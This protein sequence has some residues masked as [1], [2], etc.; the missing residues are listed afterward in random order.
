PNTLNTL[1]GLLPPHITPVPP[2]LPAPQVPLVPP[3]LSH[4]QLQ[5]PG[6]PQGSCPM[7]LLIP[8][9]GTP[10]AGLSTGVSSGESPDNPVSTR[11]VLP[12]T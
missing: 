4:P 1:S 12:R 5:P 3:P 11:N 9:L 2:G 8:T 10:E 6:T 7:G